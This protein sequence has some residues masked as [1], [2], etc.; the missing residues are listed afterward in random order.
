MDQVTLLAQHVVPSPPYQRTGLDVEEGSHEYG[1]E[2][3][4]SRGFDR[5]Q[6]H[7]EQQSDEVHRKSA[8][9]CKM[10]TLSVG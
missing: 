3:G 6:N 7:D 1:Q 5:D 2:P 9:Y 4:E 10:L 8:S